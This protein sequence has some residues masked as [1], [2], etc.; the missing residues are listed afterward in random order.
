MSNRARRRL[1]V[2]SAAI[3]LHWPQV[4]ATAAPAARPERAWV[5]RSATLAKAA[6]EHADIADFRRD[7]LAHRERLREIVRT[8]KN[9]PPEVL[10]LHRTMILTSALLSAASECHSG[11]RVVCP[12]DLMYQI[13]EQVRTGFEQLKGVEGGALPRRPS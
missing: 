5:E 4:R 10:Q 6:K 3:A 7:I 1:I 2:A 9:P 13:D 8:N 11:G 12:A